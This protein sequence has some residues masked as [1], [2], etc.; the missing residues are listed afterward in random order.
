MPHR[1]ANFAV[2]KGDGGTRLVNTYAI[3]DEVISKRLYSSLM[4][5]NASRLSGHTY[6]YRHDRTPHDAIS[7]I[8]SEFAR[9]QRLFVAE[10]D[11]S[12]F[13]DMIS[14]E[15]LWS[16]VAELGVIITPLERELTEALPAK[17]ASCI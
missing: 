10:Y 9:E 13:F 2:P 4:R 11:F 12:S 8:R 14:H 15:F 7:R 16:A 17:Q 6:A 1:P 3:A 5:K